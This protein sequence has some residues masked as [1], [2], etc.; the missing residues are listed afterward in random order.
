VSDWASIMDRAEWTQRAACR[1]LDINLFFPKRDDKRDHGDNYAP[2]ARAACAGCP[3]AAHCLMYALNNN[4]RHG[5]WGG[6]SPNQRRTIRR[7]LIA[8]GTIV[9]KPKI[10]HVAPA[11][12]GTASGY[13]AHR[14]RGEDACAE[15]KAA[16]AARAVEYRR[17]INKIECGTFAGYR[18]HHR[19]GT[20]AC[21]PCK[22]ANTARVAADR[23]TTAA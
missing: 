19:D 16:A 9:P 13:K 22:A 10:V 5:L 3:V 1:D 14:R 11:Q 17:S 8:N 4:E 15:C 2:E 12:C 21:E 7:Q 18:K 23:A 6:K 20:P